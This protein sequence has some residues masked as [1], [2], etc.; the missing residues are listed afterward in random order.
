MRDQWTCKRMCLIAAVAIQGEL[1][2]QNWSS[3]ELNIKLH[4]YA[5]CVV[6]SQR[7]LVLVL[8]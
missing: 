2:F 3:A 5:F 4:V 6:S 1:T 7:P 8:T